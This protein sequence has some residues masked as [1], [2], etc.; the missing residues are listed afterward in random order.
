MHVTCIVIRAP[1]HQEAYELTEGMDLLGFYKSLETCNSNTK[2]VVDVLL[3][4][5]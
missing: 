4:A 2:K 1:R 5:Y 3:E